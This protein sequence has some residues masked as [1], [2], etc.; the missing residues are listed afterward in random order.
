MMYFV[1]GLLDGSGILGATRSR[2]V[3]NELASWTEEELDYRTEARHAIELK[4]NAGDDPEEQHPSIYLKYT[5]SRVLTMD[6]VKGIPLIDIM[7]ALGE[8][9][10]P[11]LRRLKREGYDL[12]KIAINIM[13]NTMNQVYLH[14]YFHADLH[15]ANLFVLPGNHIGYIDYGI[16]G[17]LD[18]DTRESLAFYAHQLMQGRIERA[19]DEFMRWLDPSERTNMNAVRDE[20]AR[21]MNTYS[22]NIREEGGARQGLSVLEA[23][24][25][26]TIRRHGMSI[27]P[28]IVTYMKV[29]M[30]GMT[31][32]YELSPDFDLP[33]HQNSF[34]G[35]MML[36][37]ARSMMD[38]RKALPMMMEY[39][40]RWGRALDPR[41]FSR[42]SNQQFE[43][44][45]RRVRRR[46]Q[47]MAGLSIGSG[48]ILYLYIQRPITRFLETYFGNRLDWLPP[49]L[50]VIYAILTA[51]ILW[52]ARKLR[53]RAAKRT[54]VNREVFRTRWQRPK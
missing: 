22:L 20:L 37:Q 4:G 8:E 10:S 6:E 21:V 2:E 42:Q 31:L 48:V 33:S 11:L 9:D 38:P 43:I 46:V 15:P 18:T 26:N 50:A 52:Q 35:R 3:L 14:G 12:D 47:W 7:Y 19:A 24:V 27:S 36:Y 51:A 53:A 29:S 32:V 44:S 5:T 23:E 1:G 39:R 54:A 28:K 25:L 40:F 17:R 13:W 16:C 45:L 49:T 30:T 34:F 41:E